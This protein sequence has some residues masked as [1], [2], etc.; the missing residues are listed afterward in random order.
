MD[1][2]RRNAPVVGWQVGDEGTESE[3]DSSTLVGVVFET[4]GFGGVAGSL[5]EGFVVGGSEDLCETGL[6][7]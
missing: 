1:L 2:G 5:E 7:L 3:A 6:I 4:E